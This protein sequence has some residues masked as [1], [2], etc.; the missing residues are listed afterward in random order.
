[1]RQVIVL[2]L[3]PII[4][5]TPTLAAP[6]V[7]TASVNFRS[8][9]G[10]NFSSIR[11]L[12][13][14]T[15][16][17]IGDCEESGNWCAVTVEGRSGFVSGRYLEEKQ[18]PEGWPRAYE[19]G[20]G[21]MVLFQ[22]QF[23]EWT[24]F[25]MIEALVAAQYL[26]APDANPVF[27]VI[28][29]KGATSYDDDA[30][31]IVISDISVTQLNFSGLSRDD[32]K[33]LA[34]E[35]GKLLPAGPITV[36][37]ARVTAS[38]A[39]QKRMIDVTG[40][41]A[42][43]PRILVS[44]TPAILLQTDGEAAY[45]PVK[46]K[47]GLSFV[48][49][50]NWDL[51][52][53]EEGGTLYLRDD[54][55]W[56]TAG[57]IS[58]PW[59]VV[60]ELPPLLTSLPDDGNW[61]DASGAVPPEAYQAGKAPKIIVTDTP[62]ELILFEGEPS[63]QD[64][65]KTSL[66]WASNTEADVFYDKT[67]KQWYVLLSGRWFRAAALEGPWAFAT[68]DL[69]A[70]FQN[71][72][73]DAPYFAVRAAV[74][75]TSEAAEAR[76]K[77]SIP[78]TAR[79]E[80]GSITPTIAY[81]GDAQFAPIETTDLSYATNTTDTVIKVGE[82][83]FLL[84]DGVWFVSG[85]PNGPWQLAREVPDSIYAIPPSSPVY[86]ATYVRVYDTEPDAVWYGYTMGYL[87]GYLAW[88]TYVYGTGWAYPPYW[89]SW[90][91]Y[92]YPIYYPRPVT[93]GIGAYYNPIRGMYGRYGYTYG[94]YRGIAGARSWN[95]ATGT[96]GRA[97]AAW[98]P[99]GS[100]G[101]VGAYNPRTDGAGYVAGGR[102]VYGAWK[103]A[104]VRRGSEWARVTARDTAAG[105][106]ALRW[107]TS[108]GQGFIREGRRGDIYAGRDGNVYRNTGDGWQRF[109]GGWQ[110]VAQ[111]KG[112]ELLGRGEGREGLSP[113][114]RERLQ[115]RGEGAGL[116]ELA[117]AGA[118]GAA[119]AALGQ[120]LGSGGEQSG[121][122]R[123]GNTAGR[124]R[125]Q[126]RAEQ[127]PSGE[128][129]VQQ[130]PTAQQR[131]TTASRSPR[132]EQARPQQ[133]PAA[134]QRP[135][136]QRQAAQDR[137]VAQQRPASQQRPATK[138]RPATQRPAV[139]EQL[140]SNLMRDVQARNLGNQRQIASRQAYRPPSAQF[141]RSPASFSPQRSFAPRGGFGGG[142]FRGGGRGGGRR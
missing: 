5:T 86:N 43:P 19:V 121:R 14:G 103:S 30:G 107:N 7:I 64:V 49:N 38:L 100:A 42:D 50:S 105:G 55:H 58:G 102:N 115:E 12:P 114:G 15:A 93:W 112:G 79:V 46:G 124:E 111:P 25:K 92:A 20:K 109:D 128:R 87:S 85:S 47:T 65:P 113:E 127:R 24:D 40:L 13:T 72:P 83:Y 140:P 142:G 74:P 130:R 94:P 29:L 91:G 137:Q 2:A 88:G 22:P 54:T 122:D 117:G 18:G 3:V 28:G 39:E 138:P 136:Q 33:A 97:G 120:R 61:A 77:A 17:E 37:E 23:T 41:K 84:Q 60:T 108:N 48:V 6:G 116:R 81:A 75:G 135:S 53:I 45:A 96:Y 71:I 139:R 104:G 76:L 51:F 8:G 78:T 118:A 63:L 1:M 110:D 123:I 99:R 132:Q 35:T 69:P 125:A 26:K 98:G 70:D 34:V 57:T 52:R 32:L 21:R 101:F 95:P 89:Y 62:A 67:G 31:E 16:V 131:P 9:P 44:T 141:S 90:P 59:T 56:L 129:Q 4:A 36:A 119:G 68:P 106:S 27:G 133:R 11:T 10:A 134:Q 66:Q 126:G 82:Q 80:T 73:E